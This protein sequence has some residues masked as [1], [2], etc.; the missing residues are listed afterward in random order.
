[1]NIDTR[2]RKK[3]TVYR[4]CFGSGQQRVYATFTRK[5]DAQRWLVEQQAK[6]LHLNGATVGDETQTESS[7]T[8]GDLFH[9]F[10]ETYAS[11]RQEPGTRFREK[12][13]ADDYLIP[14]FGERDVSRISRA[15]IEGYLRGLM[16][17]GK[18]KAAT[19]NKHHQVIH[20]VFAW[21]LKQGLSSRNPAFG[22]AKLPMKDSVYSADYKFLEAGDLLKALANVRT[23]YPKEFPVIYAAATSGM[24][25]GELCA[26]QR[27]DLLDSSS[28]PVIVV[29]RTYCRVIQDFK[30]STKGKNARVVPVGDQLL[31][32]LK[33]LCL[34]KKPDDLLFFGSKEAAIMAWKNLYK[35]W[36]RAQKQSGLNP[37]CFHAL[38]HTYATQF[39][40]NGGNLFALQRILGHSNA[41]ITDKYSHFSQALIE[42]SRN[43]IQI[44]LEPPARVG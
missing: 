40:T 33:P 19:I 16:K 12:Q 36:R 14:Y 18:Q 30:D 24:R 5:T 31:E 43:V 17:K 13:I 15:D 26:L 23:L 22:L 44:P 1:M 8:F 6:S 21:A 7:Q 34:A 29:R 32:V 39:V 38:R 42:S 25:I 3:G 28:N 20:K 37:R 27:R 2:T 10:Q 11:V 41:K 9:W 35:K 4:A